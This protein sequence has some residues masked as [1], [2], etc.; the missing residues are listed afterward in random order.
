MES[1]DTKMAILNASLTYHIPDCLKM[2]YQPAI[3]GAEVGSEGKY[4]YRLG[5]SSCLSGDYMGLWN[6]DHKLQIGERTMSEDII[7]Y[8]I[9][10]INMFNGIRHP[11]IAT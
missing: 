6:F 4:T 5:E 1:R 3:R 8:T 9:V 11:A 2:P 7:Y 10:K